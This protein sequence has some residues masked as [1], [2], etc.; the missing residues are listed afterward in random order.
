MLDVLQASLKIAK[1]SRAKSLDISLITTCFM[2]RVASLIGLN[3]WVLQI[4]HRDVKLENVLLSGKT[5]KRLET[6]HFH[7]SQCCSGALKCA[8]SNKA[9]FNH[10]RWSTHFEFATCKL[11]RQNCCRTLIFCN[12]CMQIQTGTEQIYVLRLA[13]L[14][15]MRR[16]P[17]SMILQKPQEEN[18]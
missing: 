8:T 14:G 6:K 3:L 4:I 16:L 17:H 9:F 13:T 15:C 11:Y 18:T 5:R 10:L 1:C 7:L 2:W 12:Q